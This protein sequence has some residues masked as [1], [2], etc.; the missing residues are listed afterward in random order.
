M[1]CL[2][3]VC[4]TSLEFTI[5]AE[6]F[7]SVSQSRFPDPLRIHRQRRP[8]HS[9]DPPQWLVGESSFLQWVSSW[10]EQLFPAGQRWWFSWVHRQSSRDC[11]PSS[12]QQCLLRYE[13]LEE[14]KVR[15]VLNMIKP[16]RC[17]CATEGWTQHDNRSR[18][19]CFIIR[20][21]LKLTR[22]DRHTHTTLLSVLK[23][24]EIQWQKS[25]FRFVPTNITRSLR[26]I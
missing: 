26:S 11:S 8:T 12:P 7:C 22:H 25:V 3:E 2:L 9:R 20:S 10:S 24:S 18:A 15:N 1:P 13:C 23:E 21:L 19:M 17:G 4:L 6:T 5:P 16:R 14:D